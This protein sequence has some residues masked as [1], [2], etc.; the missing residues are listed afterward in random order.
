MPLTATT[1]CRGAVRCGA[2]AVLIL[3]SSLGGL[4]RADDVVVFAA[5]S[6][7]NALDDVAA[8]WKAQSGKAA[9][10]SY[11]ASSALAKQ[12]ES[13]APADVFI[14][15]DLDWMEELAKNNLIKPN[16]R[17]NLLGNR[18]VLVAPA[19]S[20]GS[21]VLKPGVDLAPALK[22]GKL[23]MADPA[24][25]PAGKYG[26]AA[27]ENLGLW[28]SVAG[29]VASAQNVR[30]ALVLVSRG[31]APLGIVYQTDAAADEGVKVVAAFPEGTHPPIL[32]P[33]AVAAASKN[34]D[35]AAFVTYLRSTSA[36]A[37][38]EKQGFTVLK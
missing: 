5:A 7:K 1:A 14:S 8:T 27:L 37:A 17:S 22:G 20:A 32:Y 28:D 15:A 16:T 36:K 19:S 26:R 38:F 33:V 10:I 12:I 25:A 13:G 34:P 29:S 11:A 4:A 21:I 31:E 24:S 30:A 23:A 3:L 35:A 18:L 9:K 6:L 2:L